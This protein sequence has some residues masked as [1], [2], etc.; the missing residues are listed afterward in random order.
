MPF[1][2]N[3]K[4][5]FIEMGEIRYPILFEEYALGSTDSAG[6]GKFRGGMGTR[7]VWRIRAKETNLSSLSERHRF[8]PY[9]VFGGLPPL[10]RP[11][12]HFCDTRIHIN[13][14]KGF[15]HATELFQKPSPSKWSN[16]TLHEGDKIELTLCCGGGWG[17]AYERD[18]EAVLSDVINDFV[19]LNGAKDHYGVVIDP[20][21]MRID[22]LATKKKRESMM[23][24]GPSIKLD[25]TVRILLT[26][27]LPHLDEKQRIRLR[28][29]ASKHEIMLIRDQPQGTVLKL[30]GNQLHE[31]ISAYIA[32]A[33]DFDMAEK[34]PLT[35]QYVPSNWNPLGS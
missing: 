21:T 30:L 27:S 11:C 23:T 13:G 8:S 22:P 3:N 12:G 16:I 26:L 19:S 29:L 15:S 25:S 9:G 7:L 31:V 35:I 20:A 2:T 34:Q 5:P 6:P 28:E 4:G 33:K 10:P 1:A 18:P 32:I 17:P 24:N 14:Q